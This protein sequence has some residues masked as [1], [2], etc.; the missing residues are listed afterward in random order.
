MAATCALKVYVADFTDQYLEC[1]ERSNSGEPFSDLVRFQTYPVF[2][3]V[4]KINTRFE[5]LVVMLL[6]VEVLD[7]FSSCMQKKMSIW[8]E[9]VLVY[10]KAFNSSPFLPRRLLFQPA[11]VSEIHA[12]VSAAKPLLT[13]TCR[14]TIQECREACGGHGYLKGFLLIFLNCEVF[15]LY[16]LSCICSNYV[17]FLLI[18]IGPGRPPQQL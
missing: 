15:T 4:N 5:V 3:T 2:Q 13:W 11:R 1:V 16:D 18:S 14:D 12:M 7:V 6:K 8:K 10:L 17:G 9:V